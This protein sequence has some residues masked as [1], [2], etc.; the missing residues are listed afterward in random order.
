MVDEIAEAELIFLATGDLGA[1]EEV[2][3]DDSAKCLAA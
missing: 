2:R 3:D 1:V